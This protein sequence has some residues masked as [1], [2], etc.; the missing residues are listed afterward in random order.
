MKA[1]VARVKG[2]L[3]SPRTEWDA[4]AKEEVPSRS[5]PWS[6]SRL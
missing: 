1:L 2:L 4:I 6:R 5:S 3:L